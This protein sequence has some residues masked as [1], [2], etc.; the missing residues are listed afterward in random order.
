MSDTSYY[1]HETLQAA[2]RYWD[3]KDAGSVKLDKAK[4]QA[5]IEDYIQ[6]GNT[7]ALATGAGD[8]VRCTPI[9]YSYHDGCFWMFSEGGK[10]FIGLAEN[11]NV[12]LAIYDK[13]EGFAKLHGIQVTGRAELIEPFNETYTAHAAFKKISLQA[14]QKLSSPM[15]LICVHPT[16]IDCLFSEFKELGCSPRQTLIPDN[17]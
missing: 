15:H 13:Y 6:R 4:L 7:C 5:M 1:T 3:E 11:S 9:E 10:K 14:L 17:A 12:C 2:A 8:Y 16:R